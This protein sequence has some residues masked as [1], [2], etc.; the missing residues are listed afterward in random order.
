MPLEEYVSESR[1]PERGRPRRQATW[2][3]C[4]GRV[5]ETILSHINYLRWINITYY[6]E[7]QD[8]GEYDGEVDGLYFLVM[9]VERCQDVFDHPTAL[10]TDDQS[11]FEHLVLNDIHLTGPLAGIEVCHDCNEQSVPKRMLLNS[12]I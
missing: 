8:S 9:R 10:E 1:A 3:C 5:P 2:Q 4:P 11:G 7:A 12:L 6:K